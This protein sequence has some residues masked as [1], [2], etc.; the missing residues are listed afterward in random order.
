MADFDTSRKETSI[1]NRKKKDIDVEIWKK[2][3]EVING[4]LHS[5]KMQSTFYVWILDCKESH[6]KEPILWSPHFLT[7][8]QANH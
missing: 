7:I 1:P 3:Q 5:K 4:A 8:M 2:N 6:Y